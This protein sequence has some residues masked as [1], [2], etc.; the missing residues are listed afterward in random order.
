MAVLGL[1]TAIITEKLKFG[2]PFADTR[3]LSVMFAD[4]IA[5]GGLIAAGI[6]LRRSPEARKRSILVATLV[7]TDAGFGRWLSPR[8]GAWLG[9][10]NYWQFQ[11]LW[12]GAWPFARF[13]LLPAYVLIAAAGIFDLLTRKRLHP[14]YAGAIGWRLA[15]HLP[16]GWLYFQP[17]WNKAALRIIGY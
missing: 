9:Q 3:F 15:L 14:A 8:I 7:L 2:T 16:A 10:R 17:F 6:R 11:T 5:F 4:M 1:M 13:Q 12:D